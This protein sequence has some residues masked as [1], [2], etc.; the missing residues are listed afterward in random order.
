MVDL[1]E[2]DSTYTGP[3]IT[4]DMVTRAE[5]VLGR[6]LPRSYVEM[7]SLRNGGVPL[8]RC[9][10]TRFPTSWADDH[11][12]IRAILGI[13]GN[14]GIDS[15]S[16]HGSIDLIAEWEYPD[17]GIVICDTPSGG[18]D[19]VMLDY[20]DSGPDNEPSVSYIDE[21]ELLDG[22]RRTSQSSWPGLPPA[23]PSD[24]QAG[25]WLTV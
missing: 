25:G 14:W 21:T 9:Y 19:T 15:S 22:S 16:G 24:D 7:L 6:S 13:G 10:P 8:R 17:I 18:H 12:E 23:R 11:F 5:Q 2:H 20:T 1:F 3:P 4:A